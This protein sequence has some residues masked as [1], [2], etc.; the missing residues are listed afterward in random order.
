MFEHMELFL[1]AAVIAAQIGL[2][3][4]FADLMSGVETALLPR[5]ALA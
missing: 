1:S 5:L 2:G 3:I 4:L